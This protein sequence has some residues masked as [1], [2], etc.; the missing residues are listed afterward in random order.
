MRLSSPW[1]GRRP[2]GTHNWFVG[3]MALLRQQS[4]AHL[5][6]QQTN[7]SAAAPS[8]LKSKSI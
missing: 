6:A 4:P 1:V 7:N 5:A 8:R 2:M 3:E